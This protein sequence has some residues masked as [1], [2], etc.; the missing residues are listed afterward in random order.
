MLYAGFITWGILVTNTGVKKQRIVLRHAAKENIGMYNI[1]I[2]HNQYNN[3]L[4]YKKMLSTKWL[5][6][7][8][9]LIIYLMHLKLEYTLI[10]V[11]MIH[12]KR[13]PM[14]LFLTVNTSEDIVWHLLQQALTKRITIMYQKHIKHSICISICL[15]GA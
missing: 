15:S 9:D 2:I 14:R 5:F 3:I 4:K 6:K 11:L 7:T 1:R 13:I 8:S 12:K 10:E